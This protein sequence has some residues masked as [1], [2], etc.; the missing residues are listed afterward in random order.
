MLKDGVEGWSLEGSG[1]EYC[2]EDAGDRREI[3]ELFSSETTR[4]IPREGGASRVTLR[5]GRGRMVG[6]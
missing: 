5:A 2:R 4:E 1:R 3:V 6:I